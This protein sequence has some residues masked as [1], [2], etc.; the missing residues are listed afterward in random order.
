MNQYAKINLAQVMHT[1]TAEIATLL[2]ELYVWMESEE[3]LPIYEETATGMDYLRA[4]AL[5]LVVHTAY[6]LEDLI[7]WESSEYGVF[8]YD[9]CETSLLSLLKDSFTAEEWRQMANNYAMPDTL[10][11]LL[12]DWVLTQPELRLKK[13][14]GF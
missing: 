4:G 10:R 1:M 9:Y 14:R 2:G 7:D 12:R 8:A 3:F 11:A 13:S 5:R 6:H